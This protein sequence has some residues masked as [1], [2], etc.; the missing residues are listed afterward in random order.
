[1]QVLTGVPQIHSCEHLCAVW[2][3]NLHVSKL[4]SL[5]GRSLPVATRVR[6]SA[7]ATPASLQVWLQEFAWTVEEK[8]EK[9][10]KRAADGQ[11]GEQ[12][13]H[14]PMFCFGNHLK[15]YT[16]ASWAVTVSLKRVK[17]LHAQGTAQKP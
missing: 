7:T 5:Y 13:A 6:C 10:L 14:E 11:V 9:Y 8:D 12:L 3:W 4:V 15:P 17:N 1:M 2:L 16:S